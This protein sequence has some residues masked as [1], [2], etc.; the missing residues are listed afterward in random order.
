MLLLSFSLPSPVRGSGHIVQRHTKPTKGSGSWRGHRIQGASCTGEESHSGRKGCPQAVI[1]VVTKEHVQGTSGLRSSP[2]VRFAPPPSHVPHP[3]SS[4]AA[5]C[6]IYV[7][8]PCRLSLTDMI[9][10]ACLCRICFVMCT[11][12]CFP[13]CC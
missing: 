6:S 4:H 7:A 8:V 10:C 2:S 11:V 13:V 1:P 3:P 12:R 5:P 9:V